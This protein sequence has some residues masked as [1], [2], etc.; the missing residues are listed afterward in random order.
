MD[1]EA[2]LEPVDTECNSATRLITIVDRAAPP[3]ARD[4]RVIV[5]QMGGQRA[6]S[7]TS[8]PA[9]TQNRRSLLS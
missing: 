4:A 3:A 1:A 9:A 5:L 6:G 7:G 2:T 8:A